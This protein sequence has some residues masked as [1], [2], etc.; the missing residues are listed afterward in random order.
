MATKILLADDSMTIHKVVS[1]TFATED[2]QIEMVTN[3]SQAMERVRE[4]LPDVVLA[5]VIMPGKNGYEVCDA[6]KS[7]PELMHIPV[8]LLVGTF[9]PFDEVEASRVK[10]DAYLTKPFDTSELIQVVRDLSAHAGAGKPEAAAESVAAEEPVLE[11]VGTGTLPE[12]QLRHLVSDRTKNSFLGS[13]RILDLFDIP[14]PEPETAP[15][16]ASQSESWPE[17]MA[18]E[19]VVAESASAPAPV[20]Q[21]PGAQRA[22]GL[23][24]GPIP[25]TE[26]TINL[27]VERV[28]KR[29]S[30]SV[31]RD[32]A[33]EVVPALSE[34]LIRQYLEDLRPAPKD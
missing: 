20:I 1:L 33:W 4:F 29:L 14:A 10:C 17:P 13:D 12:A 6:I 27:I 24:S 18:G 15:V 2:V 21:F 30:D 16:A 11:A 22:T 8:I 9:E 3:G 26:E 23:E 32:I 34:I 25:L 28:V 19:A 5:D 7:D 31:V